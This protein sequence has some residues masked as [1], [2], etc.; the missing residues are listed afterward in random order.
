MGKNDKNIKVEG[1]NISDSESDGNVFERAERSKKLRDKIVKGKKHNDKTKK[2]KSKVNEPSSSSES[3]SD[4]YNP[5]RVNDPRRTSSSE[6]DS[7][8]EDG[9]SNSTS[10]SEKIRKLTREINKLKGKNMS[11]DFS[12]SASDRQN[13]SHRSENNMIPT[14]IKE[15]LNNLPNNYL[16][17]LPIHMT[18]SLPSID[19]QIGNMDPQMGMMGMNQ[20]MNPQMSQMMNQQQQIAD[21]SQLQQMTTYPQMPQSMIEAAYGSNAGAM[22][23]QQQAQPN[24]MGQ[25][26]GQGNQFNNT[27]GVPML[28]QMGMVP[29]MGG[30]RKK[31]KLVKEGNFF[32]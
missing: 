20:M 14:Q 1:L 23:G 24:P 16:G 2:N 25:L 22:M 6:S 12:T 19:G 18:G 29:Q 31:Y 5:S 3:D 28:G 7:L 21:M 32:F 17:E 13:R 15:K 9:I 30:S 11:S 27:L 26:L 8:T 10:K 4:D